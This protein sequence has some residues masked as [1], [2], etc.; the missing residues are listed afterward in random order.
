[1][2]TLSIFIIYIVLQKHLQLAETR[3]NQTEIIDGKISYLSIMLLFPILLA[4]KC[5]FDASSALMTFDY[6]KLALYSLGLFVV[7][8]VIFFAL[9]KEYKKNKSVIA[10]VVLVLLFFSPTSVALVNK[11]LDFTA[12]QK[13]TCQVVDKTSERDEYHNQEYYLIIKYNDSEIKTSVR[14]DRYY[15]TAVG[16]DVVVLRYNGALGIERVIFKE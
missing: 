3:F 6:L 10:F 14:M 1:M 4:I 13:I 5:L 15:S 8:L 7:L 9:T 2:L 16:E 12:P 11:N